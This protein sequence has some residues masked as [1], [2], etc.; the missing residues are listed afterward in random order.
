VTTETLTK[1]LGTRILAPVIVDLITIYDD[2]SDDIDTSTVPII[3]EANTEIQ[4]TQPPKEPQPMEVA[5]V[6]GTTENITTQSELG[7]QPSKEEEAQDEKNENESEESSP[8]EKTPERER[9]KKM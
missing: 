8:E 3:N 1:T 7:S 5:M 9:M 2:D 6:P 4:D